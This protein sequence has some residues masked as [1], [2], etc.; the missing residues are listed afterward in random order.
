MLNQKKFIK[1]KI[2]AIDKDISAF[3]KGYNTIV[4]EKDYSVVDKNNG[5]RL[6]EC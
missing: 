3:E 1:A 4:G 2:A 5:W 6:P